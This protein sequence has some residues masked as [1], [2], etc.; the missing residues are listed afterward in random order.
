MP[1]VNIDTVSDKPQVRRKK[2]VQISNII[3]TD[4]AFP[5]NKIKIAD[6]AREDMGDIESLMATIAEHGIMQPVVIDQDNNLIA[7]GRRCEAVRRLGWSTIPVT[8]VKVDDK[9]TSFEL[10]LLENIGR[11]DMTWYEQAELYHRIFEARKADDPKWSMNKQAL[12][13]GR[14]SSDVQRYLEAYQYCQ[15]APE[16]KKLESLRQVSTMALKMAQ[17]ALVNKQL[18]E[19]R[20][21]QKAAEAAI[22]DEAAAHL[23]G[24]EFDIDGDAEAPL[25]INE[26]FDGTPAAETIAEKRAADAEQEARRLRKEAAKREARRKANP[27]AFD[28]DEAYQIGDALLEM[29]KEEYRGTFHFAEVDP[30]YGIALAE[31][32]A[33]SANPANKTYNEIPA[34]QYSSFIRKAA[35]GVFSCLAPNSFCVWWFGEDWRPLVRALLE[36]AGFSV[37]PIA[38]IWTKGDVGQTNNPQ[39]TLANSYES[40]FVARKGQPMLSKPGRSNRFDFPGVH[41]NSRWHPT[42]RPAELIA[43][44]YNTF[45]P[46]KCRIL[47]PFMGSGQSAIVALQQGHMPLGWDISEQY[48]ARYITEGLERLGKPAADAG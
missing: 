37:N 38:A 4:P 3:R 30:P 24:E 16:L 35:Q 46:K 19:I 21:K 28:L 6:R 36:Q 32:R 20:S 41:G 13:L 22:D 8:I 5:F 18:S 14:S 42:Q 9:A 15:V 29:Q 11:K 27:I 33:K 45:A 44:L 7:G 25:G 39:T 47:V 1:S 40:F 23:N 12:F 31:K 26:L 2:S 48:K 43:E 10:E 34:E 17:Q